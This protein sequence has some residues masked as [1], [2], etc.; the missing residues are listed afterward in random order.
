MLKQITTPIAAERRNESRAQAVAA[1]R[2][3]R[4][5]TPAVTNLRRV[6]REDARTGHASS[7]AAAVGICMC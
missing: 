1:R 6:L 5:E 3:E 2:A 7:V 4:R